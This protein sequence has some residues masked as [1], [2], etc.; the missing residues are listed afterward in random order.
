[1]IKTSVRPP[2]G[3]FSAMV[4]LLITLCHSALSHADIVSDNYDRN[5]A[6]YSGSLPSS[7]ELSGGSTKNLL[8]LSNW[9]NAVIEIS[10]PSY[11]NCYGS[12]AHTVLR[13]DSYNNSIYEIQYRHYQTSTYLT[14]G[15]I[16]D[17][18]SEIT[19]RSAAFARHGFF[20][21]FNSLYYLSHG[22]ACASW[23]Q[24]QSGGEYWV[25]DREHDPEV[26]QGI[27][28]YVATED[29]LF[30]AAMPSDAFSDEDGDSLT[31]SV[32]SLPAWLN[33]TG[34]STLSGTAN[35]AQVGT[36]SLTIT[37]TDATGRSVSDSFSLTVLNDN[38]AP[39]IDQG[40]VEQTVTEDLPFSFSVPGDVFG[41]EDTGDSLSLTAGS[42]PSWLSFDPATHVFSGTA[43]NQQVGSHVVSLTA[44]D[45]SAAQVSTSFSLTVDNSNDAPA[46][47]QG[48][49]DQIA[50]EDQG[51]SLSVPTD[52]FSDQ[53]IGDTI[54]YSLLSAPGWLS[55]SSNTLSGTPLQADVGNVQISLQ[56]IDSGSLSA[57]TSFSIDVSDVIDSAPVITSAGSHSFDE[58]QTD[59]G[60]QL[61]SSDLDSDDTVSYAIASGA[62]AALFAVDAISGLL[63][64]VQPLD[65]ENPAD[66]DSDNIY[67]LVLSATDSATLVGTI[68]LNLLLLD[69]NDTAPV[70]ISQSSVMLAE[71]NYASGYLA[72][73][74]D[75][76]QDDSPAQS[77][78][79]LIIGGAD[80]ALFE[81]SSSTGELLF[82]VP[83]DFENPD[84]ANGDHVYELLLQ[85]T[86]T[87]SHSTALNLQVSIT[88]S[89]DNGPSFS[90]AGT[91]VV[92]E[93]SSGAIYTAVASDPDTN[94][95]IIFSLVAGNDS[96]LFSIDSA[97]GLLSV[98][99]LDFESPGIGAVNNV[100]SLTARGT[101][102][103]AHTQDHNVSVTV[104]DINDTAPTI[105]SATQVTILENTSA[106]Y[107]ATANDPDTNDSL[108]WRLI[109]GG[110]AALFSI[111]SQRGLLSFST[112]PDAES[113]AD[114]DADND[115]VLTI[116]AVDAA[117]NAATSSLTITVAD[118]N[119]APVIAVQSVDLNEFSPIATVFGELS[120]S[121]PEN[122]ALH[123]SLLSA[124]SPFLLDSDGR[125]S[126]NGPIDFEILQNYALDIQLSDGIL[127]TQVIINVLVQDQNEIL[128]LVEQLPATLSALIT[129]GVSGTITGR[130]IYYNDSIAAATPVPSTL[131]QLQAIIDRA[132]RTADIVLKINTGGS[133]TDET[134]IDQLRLIGVQSL[135][136]DNTK[137]YQQAI[138]ATQ[139][140]PTHAGA[141]QA[142]ID[143]S[144]TVSDVL[145]SAVD[146]FTGNTTDSAELLQQISAVAQMPH[147]A[148]EHAAALAAA[149]VRQRPAPRTEQEL[150]VIAQSLIDRV[151]T[152]P[153][154]YL[155]IEQQGVQIQ[156]IDRDKGPVTLTVQIANPAPE[157]ISYFDWSTTSSNILQHATEANPVSH[158]L[159]FDPS[160]LAAG[161]N[162]SARAIVRRNEQQAMAEMTVRVISATGSTLETG[163]A[164]GDGIV[165]SVDGNLNAS[166]NP[167]AANKLQTVSGNNTAYLI[168]A[169]SGVVMRLG[170]IARNARDNQAIIALSDIESHTALELDAADSVNIAPHSSIF[171]FEV[172]GLPYAGA[173]T[174]VVL[175]LQAALPEHAVYQKFHVATGWQPYVVDGLNKIHSAPALSGDRGK[176]PAAQHSSWQAGLSAGHQ[177]I[178]LSLEDGGPNDADR[179]STDGRAA[180]DFGINGNIRDPGAVFEVE[181]EDPLGVETVIKGSGSI[182]PSNLLILLSFWLFMAHRKRSTIA[183]RQR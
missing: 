39:F 179:M 116:E 99:A 170:A 117:G 126:V 11:T 24:V 159:I 101:D 33:F 12:N 17:G 95:P 132:N 150:I 119:E 37:A 85:A 163:D 74:T 89:N 58:G 15:L 25:F 147:I 114:G 43:N 130:E 36:Y 6:D 91:V 68:T 149:L 152:H 162:I 5:T 113:P 115:H 180:V 76:D 136:V 173:T 138:A 110:D 8:D 158:S 93:G 83:P 156:S 143:E 30:S 19:T 66:A 61:S 172:R 176:C 84:D 45:T 82:R 153:V 127:S 121:D 128:Q 174:T 46:V 181:Q 96:G 102:S 44:A 73:A 141:I 67:Q 28:D 48:I 65:R 123:W 57:I 54:T 55:I 98:S 133:E 31:L 157:H 111:D 87:A 49:A 90:S 38:D 146:L 88:D 144:N 10:L 109:D 3:A 148:A 23:S 64:A 22:S 41:D 164:D 97:S 106:A 166:I 59:T 112:P 62:D 47:D 131:A 103:A 177:C 20:I 92:A 78:S 182:D 134:L 107:Q 70:F 122:D 2:S 120:G 4:L 72:A 125:L 100:Y 135:E 139:P 35:N 151:H 32:S 56:A 178:R 18:S 71:D 7:G 104:T 175:P 94:D 169:D 27:P 168:G 77:L 108:S 105:T 21:S 81:L 142:L 42:L 167:S 52:A 69:T 63:T 171:D 1:M 13:I 53:D 118:V 155:S 51:F 129:E 165:D 161:R 160:T 29:S 50:V 183:H 86:D 154:V 40:M 34:G 80:A 60:Y 75:P 137:R 14:D 145:G 9:P 124:S 140:P 26:N 16:G 79:Y